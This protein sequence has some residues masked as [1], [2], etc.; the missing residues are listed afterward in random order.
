MPYMWRQ[1]GGCGS[2]VR[3]ADVEEGEADALVRAL[4]NDVTAQGAT[5]HFRAG[6]KGVKR[7]F[8][9]HYLH[10]WDKVGPAN[11]PAEQLAAC[12]GECPSSGGTWRRVGLCRGCCTSQTM[13]RFIYGAWLAQL[14]A[15]AAAAEL[16][17]DEFLL[18][19][20]CPV[21]IG[22]ARCA[23]ARS[24]CKGSPSL[25]CCINTAQAYVLVH[26]MSSLEL[27]IAH[28]SLVTSVDASQSTLCNGQHTKQS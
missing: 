28:A 10:M 3:R 5:D 27:A 20:L 12:P 23:H 9:G 15:E 22:L 13:K 25:C 14:L 26:L 19:T 8:R 4:L 21:L 7:G 11:P 1:A 24:T 17:S 18:D 6:G 2:A 16:L